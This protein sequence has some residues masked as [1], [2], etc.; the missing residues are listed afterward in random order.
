MIQ[1]ER[2]KRLNSIPEG[3]GDYVLYWMQSSQ[4][5][6]D[7]HALEYAI[8][9]ADTMNRP[10]V[11]Y[12][13]LTPSNPEAN[14]RHFRFMAEGLTETAE[15]LSIRRIRLVMRIEE[16]HKGVVKLAGRAACLVMDCGYLRHQRAWRTCAARKVKCPVFQVESDV[17]VPVETVSDKENYSAGTLRPRHHRRWIPF[18]QPLE[19]RTPRNSSLSMDLKGE[20][21]AS[22]DEIMSRISVDQSVKPSPFFHGGTSCALK[23]LNRFIDERLDRYD[24]ERNDPVLEGQSGLSPYLHFG[25]ISPLTVALRVWDHPAR[26]RDAFLDELIVRRELSVNF[27]H[28]QPAYDSVDC[29]PDWARKTLAEHRLDPHP[30]YSFEQ[31]DEARTDDPYWNAAQ[32]QMRLTGKMHGYMRMYWGKKILE[33]SPNI[34]KAYHWALL[35]NNKYELDGRD[36]NGYAGVAWCFG[37]HDRAWP[38]RPV[39]GKVRSMNANGLRRKFRVDE[40]V[41]K[42]EAMIRN[43]AGMSH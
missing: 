40:Y 36:P 20:S 33:W 16:P 1:P 34:E 19:A 13:G 41:S 5:V 26:G 11:V 17:L 10:V 14:A 9:L 31:L 42:I 23:R 25:Q 28:Y 30:I 4:R 6:L 39:F 21:A 27:V 15:A 12:F 38:A 22:A 43:P 29:L 35:M 18:L 8:R 24:E 2:I 7:N 37:K 32:K 3:S